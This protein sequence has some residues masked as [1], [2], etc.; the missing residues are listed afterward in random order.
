MKTSVLFSAVFLMSAT[1]L[2]GQVQ[3]TSH[4]SCGSGCSEGCQIYQ[5]C[6]WNA[7]RNCNSGGWCQSGGGYGWNHCD[8]NHCDQWNNGGWG[9]NYD[10]TSGC[11]FGLG[12]NGN[13]CLTNGGG[14][15][16]FPGYCNQCNQ[17]C[18]ARCCATKAY[19]DAGWNPPVHLPVNRDGVWYQSYYPSA[20]YGN[21]GGGFTNSYP[22]V[23]QP[24][25]T[26]QLGY[27]Y[28]KV[29]TWQT[30]PGMIPP[31][32]NPRDYHL[33]ACLTGGPAC[34]TCQ[35]G[36][37]AQYSAVPQYRMP[38]AMHPQPMTAQNRP[39]PV[40]RPASGQNIRRFF[41]LSALTELFED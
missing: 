34:N 31:A 26:T 22:Q 20:F 36:Y 33:R 41:R 27:Y 24:T 25:D 21:P 18:L 11:P 37:Q 35:P 29:P 6:D 8:C 13:S 4:S 23:Y 1:A 14:W 12:C 28:H 19:P 7:G 30:R 17:S 3:Q 15:N 2:F 32:P 39:M 40:V 5:P 16:G 10:P 38:V 9:L